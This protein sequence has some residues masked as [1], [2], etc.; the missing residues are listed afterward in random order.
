MPMATEALRVG[1]IGTGVMGRDHARL[2]ST[3]VSGARLVAVADVN[4]EGTRALAAELDV[5]LVYYDGIDLIE[6]GE[7]DAVIIASPDRFHAGTAISCIERG[8]PVLCEKP[9]APTAAEASDVVDAVRRNPG[10][11][12]TV[13]FM[14]RF[15]PGYAA[16]KERLQSGADGAVL[17]TH[18]VHRNVEAYPG[19][20]SSATIMN[21]AV[22]EID[23]VRWLTGSRI[24]EVMWTAGRASSL[25]SERHDPQ[26]VLLRDSDDVLHTIELQMHAQYGYDVR[27]ELVCERASIELPAPPG[28]VGRLPLVVSSELS[29]STAYPRDWRPRFEE[30]YRLELSAWVRAS[31]VGALPDGAAT[32]QEAYQTTVIA[33]AVVES[34]KRGGWVRLAAVEGEED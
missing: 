14:R 34:M 19:D 29:R 2:L 12:A 32:V 28:L 33:E 20:D 27:C 15:D 17:M 3:Q 21:S 30:A 10:A 26:L 11:L 1:I 16:M 5:P 8:L 24:V 31:L 25:I 6:S 7:V 4:D 22:H 23:I 18:S 9:L 13:G